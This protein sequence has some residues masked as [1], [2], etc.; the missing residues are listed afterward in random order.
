MAVDAGDPGDCLAS[1]P[2]ADREDYVQGW[3]KLGSLSLT[4]G[5]LIWASLSLTPPTAR[6]GSHHLKA[7]GRRSMSSPP[8]FGLS[9]PL[10][11]A[12]EHNTLPS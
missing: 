3:E 10:S 6:P 7:L 9:S 8:Q 5:P 2:L 4:W 11:P 1:G 12:S